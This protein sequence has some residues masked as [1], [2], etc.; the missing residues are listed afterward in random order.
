MVFS[1]SYIRIVY[2]TI[3]ALSTSTNIS[4]NF[5]T[6]FISALSENFNTIN[7]TL[8]IALHE[9]LFSES[10]ILILVNLFMKSFFSFIWMLT[11]IWTLIWCDTPYFTYPLPFFIHIFIVI[12]SEIPIEEEERKRRHDESKLKLGKKAHSVSIEVRWLIPIIT[13]KQFEFELILLQNSHTYCHFHEGTLFKNK[14]NCRRK[15]LRYLKEVSR[16][17]IQIYLYLKNGLINLCTN[18]SVLKVQFHCFFV[19]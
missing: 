7:S 14:K 13:R 10:V 4:H 11:I 15:C 5:V 1:K 8:L 3:F 2:S 17:S 9:F 19:A 6:I 18:V 12:V 16:I